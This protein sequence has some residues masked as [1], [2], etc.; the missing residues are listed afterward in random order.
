MPDF[1]F[2]MSVPCMAYYSTL[3]MEAVCASETPVKFYQT[4]RCHNPEDNILHNH[5]CT[6]VRYNDVT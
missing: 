1:A 3:K 2:F 5:L 6:N 4:T